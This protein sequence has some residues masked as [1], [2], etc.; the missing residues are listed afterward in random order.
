MKPLNCYHILNTFQ[1]N[2]KQ[3]NDSPSK[4]TSHQP[5]FLLLQYS[6]SPMLPPYYCWTLSML[7]LFSIVIWILYPFFRALCPEYKLHTTSW[8]NFSNC[9]ELLLG[10]VLTASCQHSSLA[11][12]LPCKKV[13]RFLVPR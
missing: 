13:V 2:K 9:T 10:E 7:T 3:P 6:L 8:L 5:R 1:S 4:V 11:S 12:W